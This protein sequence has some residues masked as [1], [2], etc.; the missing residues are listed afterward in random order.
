MDELKESL[1]CPECGDPTL[2][3]D[4]IYPGIHG[5]WMCM[6]CYYEEEYYNW[7]DW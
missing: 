4:V 5:E 7:K 3:H 1:E 6:A 2:Y